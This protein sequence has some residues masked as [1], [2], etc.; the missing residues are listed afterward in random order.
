MCQARINGRTCRE[1]LQAHYFPTLYQFKYEVEDGRTP[2][3]TAVR[4][5]FDEHEFQ[6]YSWKGY[7]VFSTLQNEIIRDVSIEKPSLYRMVLRYVNPNPETV[8]G[9]VMINPD[10]PTDIEQKFDVQFK[11][12]KRPTF[13]TVAGPHGTIPSPL[14]MNPGRWAVSIKSNKKLFLV[15][16]I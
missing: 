14:V 16:F 12:A 8:H 5:G 2:A 15:S 9:I 1:P 10:N 4:Y 6:G 13:V 3:N 11:P 7:G